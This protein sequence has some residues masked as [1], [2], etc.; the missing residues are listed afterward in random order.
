VLDAMIDPSVKLGTSTP[1]SDPSGDYAWAV[2]GKAE[3]LR[4]GSRERLEAK[5]MTLVG[6]ADSAAPPP[7]VSGYAWHLREGRA[8]LFLTYCTN[9]RLAAG[10]LPDARTVELSPELAT[11]A[12]Y[13]LTVLKGADAERAGALAFFILSP[14]GQGILARHGFDAPLLPQAGSMPAR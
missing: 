2:F 1:G 3:A 12:E 7:G 8:D 6:A 11:G 13:G 5:T 10:E 9:A 14:E 4:P